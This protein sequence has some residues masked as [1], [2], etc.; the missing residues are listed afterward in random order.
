VYGMGARVECEGWYVHVAVLLR[1]IVVLNP[2]CEL[3][4]HRVGRRTGK[5]TTSL[6]I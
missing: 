3:G 5:S 1:Y 6:R 2:W 4:V